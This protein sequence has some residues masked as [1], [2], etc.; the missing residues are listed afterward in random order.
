MRTIPFGRLAILLLIL[1]AS[2]RAG[3]KE[4]LFCDHKCR[5]IP[6]APCPDCH[7]PC[8]H[9]LCLTPFKPC[10]AHQYIE[11]LCSGDCCG[12]I[13]AAKK[14]GWRL[15]ADVCADPA[16][17]D[18]LLGALL[19]DTCWEVRRAA[20]TSLYLQDARFENALLA[21]YISSKL[22]PHYMVR[23]KATEA[24]DIL[25]VCRKP[26]YKELFEFGDK[27]IKELR[28]KKYLPG[29]EHC[30]EI[31]ASV[32]A[33]CGMTLASVPPATGAQTATR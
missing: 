15:H 27:L 30:K 24:L 8:E 21:L 29:S 1:S 26:C 18:A 12:R 25:T 20:A 14:L 23:T 13:K 33:T 31:L 28:S 6:P 32:C 3:E 4:C 10:H 22:D 17:L 7:G 9:R 19:C 16:V 2:A 5:P 11:T